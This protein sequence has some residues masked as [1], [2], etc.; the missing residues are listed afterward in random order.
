[1]QLSFQERKRKKYKQ[2]CEEI[3]K[4]NRLSDLEFEIE[5]LNL[6]SEYEYKKNLFAVF[7][8]AILLAVLTN[9][10]KGFFEFIQKIIQYTSEPIANSGEIAKIGFFIAII[11]AVSVTTFLIM[12]LLTYV[13]RLYYVHRQILLFELVKEKKNSICHGNKENY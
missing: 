4:L 11:L 7:L 13:K 2:T 8:V 1:M 9:V 10:W 6:K 3:E 12:G 5:Y